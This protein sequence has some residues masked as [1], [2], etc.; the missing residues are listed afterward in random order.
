MLDSDKLN[1]ERI[2]FLLV[3]DNPQALLIAASVIAGF[4]VRQIVKAGN[5]R[6]AKEI[7]STQPI[8]FLLT[9]AQMPGE[10]GYALVSWLRSNAPEHNRF[11]PVVIITGHTRQSH[12]FQ[13]RDCG[14]NAIVA[15]PLIPKVLLERI[16]WVAR[17]RRRFI[18]CDNY[19]GPD[20]RFRDVGPPEGIDGRR[21][22][23][24]KAKSGAPEVQ[25]LE[26]ESED[27]IKRAG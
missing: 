7:L 22:E 10:D 4:G 18:E 17:D 20:R 19:I 14:V 6:D 2:Q 11:I 5:V 21:E 8:D 15:K 3:D 24:S 9:D 26:I 16:Y 1:L 23:D 12:V 27:N 13:A 25:S